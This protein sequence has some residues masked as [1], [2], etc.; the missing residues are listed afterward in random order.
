[1]QGAG[2]AQRLH[3]PLC[4]YG[5]GYSRIQTGYLQR[6]LRKES[7][8]DGVGRGGLKD[9]RDGNLRRNHN[10]LGKEMPR[11][12]LMGMNAIT[13]ALPHVE[14]VEVRACP[15]ESHILTLHEYVFETLDNRC[16]HD[17]RCRL[18]FYVLCFIAWHRSPRQRSAFPA[19]QPHVT[20]SP[21]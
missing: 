4:H 11:R 6:L 20:A 14:C 21:E 17:R 7:E 15:Y 5:R 8:G 1:M 9:G 12:R 2:H 19:S 10:M 3:L 18:I 16:K 13:F